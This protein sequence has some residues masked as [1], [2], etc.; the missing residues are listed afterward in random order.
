LDR[1]LDGRSTSVLR[2]TRR[3]HRNA[4]VF[5]GHAVM[6]IVDASLVQLASFMAPKGLV[7]RRP[8]SPGV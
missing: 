7:H 6:R 5:R 4:D 2:D 8:A 3:P 1:G